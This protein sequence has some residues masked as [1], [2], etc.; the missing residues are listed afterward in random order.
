MQR[1]SIEEDPMKRWLIALTAIAVLSLACV[2]LALATG[3]AGTSKGH[4]KVH[5]KFQ[6]EAVLAPDYAYAPGGPLMVVVKSG[7][8]TVKASRHD[9]ITVQV[10]ATAKLINAT[11]DPAVPLVLSTLAAGDKVHLGGAIDRVDPKTPST[12]TFTATR[13]ILQQVPVTP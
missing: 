13:V 7:S 3:H 9:E 8:K 1:R 6:C 2:P 5:V 4:M 10:A 11:V 12:W